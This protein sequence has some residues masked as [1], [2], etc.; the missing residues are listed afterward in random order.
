MGI[1]GVDPVALVPRGRYARAR[2]IWF[3]PTESCL[4]NWLE[5]V[6]FRKVEC[7]FNEQLSIDEQRRTEWADI[8]S[9]KDFL[10]EDGTETVEGYPAP[11]RIYFKAIK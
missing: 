1:P 10:S 7:F 2:G 5:R 9:L 11:R 8:D 6:P 3:L 4:K